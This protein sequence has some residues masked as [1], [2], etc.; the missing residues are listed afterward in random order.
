[1]INALNHSAIIIGDLGG[2]RTSITKW[3]RQSLLKKSMIKEEVDILRA[4][5]VE[6]PAE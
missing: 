2:R 6:T 1:M 5:Y 4:Y 3:Q